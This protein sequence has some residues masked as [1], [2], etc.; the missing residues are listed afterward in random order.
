[1]I[2]KDR[3][4]AHTLTENDLAAILWAAGL[5]SPDNPWHESGVRMRNLIVLM[6][7][8]TGMRSREVLQ[9]RIGD[10]DFEAGRVRVSYP[11]ELK[12]KTVPIP[13]HLLDLLNVTWLRTSVLLLAM[14]MSSCP[15][16]PEST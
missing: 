16:A 10:I 5:Q 4:S 8:F 12:R 9:M 14:T 6:L 1:M 15:T 13:P 2:R 3:E 7:L 11:Y